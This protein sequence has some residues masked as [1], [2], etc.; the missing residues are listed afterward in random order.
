MFLFQTAHSALWPSLFL[1]WPIFNIMKMFL[2]PPFCLLCFCFVR[3][4]CMFPFSTISACF[5]HILSQRFCSL[6]KSVLDHSYSPLVH[7]GLSL[8][9]SFLY[10]CHPYMLLLEAE[11]PGWARGCACMPDSDRV[12]TLRTDVCFAAYQWVHLKDNA[13][14]LVMVT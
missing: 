4:D 7:C 11:L 13:Q 2:F 9:W 5:L 3:S 8:A 10:F 12:C 6:V 14:M 1:F